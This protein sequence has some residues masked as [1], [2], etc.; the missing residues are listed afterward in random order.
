MGV[1]WGSKFVAFLP[2]DVFESKV[3]QVDLKPDGVSGTSD[4]LYVP[5][6]EGDV[7]HGHEQFD[8]VDRAK[9]AVKRHILLRTGS[10]I[11]SLLWA[12]ED[13][14][15][16][17]ELIRMT[18]EKSNNNANRIQSKKDSISTFEA[19]LKTFRAL[20]RAKVSIE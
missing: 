18:E 1:Y 2:K 9:C 10:E 15:Q 16:E 3:V 17:I 14:R 12:I 6:N 4:T 19:D 7:L 8:C 5:V 20:R 11:Q 13:A